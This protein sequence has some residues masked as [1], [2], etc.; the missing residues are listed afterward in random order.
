MKWTLSYVVQPDYL[1]V[2]GIPL[3]RGR[4]FTVH[5]DEHSPLVAVVD[6]VFARKYFGDENP[7][8]KR[9]RLDHHR[10]RRQRHAGRRSSASSGT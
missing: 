10:S 4:F 1:K 7:L 2:M 8:G 6:D 9:I 3:R 5:D